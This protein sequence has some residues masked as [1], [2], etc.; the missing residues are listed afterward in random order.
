MS[1][2]ENVRRWSSL[3]SSPC[4]G[5]KWYFTRTASPSWVLE[6][7]RAAIADGAVVLGVRHRVSLP[8]GQGV[9]ALVNRI[10]HGAAPP[11]AVQAEGFLELRDLGRERRLSDAAGGRSAPEAAVL[12]D[13]ERVLELAEREGMR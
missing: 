4:L 10:L 8:R 11:R 5:R 1:E 13:R 2:Y 7:G 12:G 3:S 6:D 9:G